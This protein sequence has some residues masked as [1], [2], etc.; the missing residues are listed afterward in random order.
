MLTTLGRPSST[1]APVTEFIAV[2][3]QGPNGTIWIDGNGKVTNGNGTLAAPKPNAFSLVQVADCPQATPTCK[4]ACYVWNLEK[5]APETHRLYKHNSDM[6][7][8]IVKGVHAATWAALLG[9]WITANCAG[10]FRWHVSGDIWSA[11]YADWIRSVAHQSQTVQHWIYT[12]S[13]DFVP[14]LIGQ[15]FSSTIIDSPAFNLTVNLSCDRDNY[16][17]ARELATEHRLRCCY[18]T[19]DGALPEDL[20]PG[21]V[22]FPDYNLRGGTDEG[23]RWFDALPMHYKK[24]VCPVDY[25]GKSEERR[26]GPCPKC[27]VPFKENT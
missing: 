1:S 9:E 17:A 3:L 2:E 13:F 4:H 24:M 18:L 27:I 6:I 5:H 7:R 25:H 10:G 19:T 26:C 12:R 20:R 16:A 11:D 22:I 14:R 21:D 8:E 23:A 15:R